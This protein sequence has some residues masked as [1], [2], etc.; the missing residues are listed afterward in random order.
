MRN[1]MQVKLEITAEST[2]KAYGDVDPVR[3]RVKRRSA[4]QPSPR[5]LAARSQPAGQ[6]PTIRRG[7]AADMSVYDWNSRFA[8]SSPRIRR[9]DVD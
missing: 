8:S 4:T 3:W 6:T 2:D 1:T 5:P 9:I 7:S